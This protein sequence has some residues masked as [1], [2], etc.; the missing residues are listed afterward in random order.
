MQKPVLRSETRRLLLLR[1]SCDVTCLDH[2]VRVNWNIKLHVRVQ[3]ANVVKV[4]EHTIAILRIQ[5]TANLRNLGNTIHFYT[6]Q[7]S[8]Y[9]TLTTS[10]WR[11]NRLL[12]GWPFLVAEYRTKMKS[13]QPVGQNRYFTFRAMVRLPWYSC[14]IY[15]VLFREMFAIFKWNLIKIVSVVSKNIAILF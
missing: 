6:V 11:L 2:Q 7:K 4:T 12:L 3:E 15:A 14:T 10:Y 9:L 1:G 5:A 8:L 13:V